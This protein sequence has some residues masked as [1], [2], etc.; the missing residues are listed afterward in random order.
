MLREA[1]TI[2]S[3]SGDVEISRR[4]VEIKTA[5]EP[6][7]WNEIDGACGPASKCGETRSRRPSPAPAARASA[8]VRSHRTPGI[9]R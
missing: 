5:S 8:S 9:Q 1:N 6:G 2:A 4:V 7:R 3:K